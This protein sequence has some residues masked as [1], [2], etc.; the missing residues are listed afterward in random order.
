MI[1]GNGVGGTL[2][3]RRVVASLGGS[4][5]Y[6]ERA[7]AGRASFDVPDDLALDDAVALL[8]DG[9]TATLLAD[10]ARTRSRAS[11]CSS[12]AAAGGVGTLLVQLAAPRRR[13][14]DRRGEHA[15]PS[16]ARGLAGRA[17]RP[18]A[19]TNLKR[20]SPAST[21]VFDGV[22]GE[23][24]RGR[25]RSAGAGRADALLRARERVVGGHQRRGG[26][27]A[28]RHARPAGPA[29]SAQHTE[30]ALAAGL[31]PIIGQ[32]FPLEQAPRTPTRP[33]KPARR[34]ARRCWRSN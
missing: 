26:R 12:L 23:V 19:T 18:S 29:R 7:V 20:D 13:D 2:D 10:A 14:R 32:R 1:P 9:R 6:A 8:A 28:R 4:G 16:A 25:V 15:T 33:S 22:G 34:S 5:G 31:T 17:P 24:A 3:G 30:R 11:A 27:G 21:F